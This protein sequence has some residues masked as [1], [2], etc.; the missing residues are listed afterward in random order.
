[1]K[2]QS[3]KSSSKSSSRKIKIKFDFKDTT[4]FEKETMFEG[5]PFKIKGI[6]DFTEPDVKLEERK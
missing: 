2:R 5:K 4:I 1:M 3:S 6:F